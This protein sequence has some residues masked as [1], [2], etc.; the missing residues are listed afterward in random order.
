M[1]WPDLNNT[2]IS[3][4]G[5]FHTYPT[6]TMP[7]LYPTIPTV[8]DVLTIVKLHE[9]SEMMLSHRWTLSWALGIAEHL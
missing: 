8:F 1:L 4:R 9:F 5:I 6:Y 2:A 7:C 3:K